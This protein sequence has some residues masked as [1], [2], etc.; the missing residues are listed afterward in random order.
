LL[1]SSCLTQRF[2]SLASCIRGSSPVAN[3][4]DIQLRELCLATNHRVR[5][6]RHAAG[7]TASQS[8]CVRPR[9]GADLPKPKGPASRGLPSLAC[10]GRSTET[11][12]TSMAFPSFCRCQRQQDP[13]SDAAGLVL[14]SCCFR[15]SLKLQFAA[16]C[17]A[18]SNPFLAYSA[19]LVHHPLWNRGLPSVQ[20]A[21]LWHGRLKDLRS[22]LWLSVL[23]VIITRSYKPIMGSGGLKEPSIRTVVAR[24]GL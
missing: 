17:S 22:G 13:Q 1:K 24:F 2:C 4:F 8:T 5:S 23:D 16:K 21:L 19:F 3:Q 10:L 6:Q 15:G 7:D 12:A 11:G 18:Q 9:S 20:L 14:R